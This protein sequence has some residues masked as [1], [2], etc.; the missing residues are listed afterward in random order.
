MLRVLYVNS[1]AEM[2]GGAERSLLE[3][4]ERDGANPAVILWSM[5]N[6]TPESPE[7]NAF[8][9]AFVAD[10]NRTRLR[11][12]GHKA[13]CELLANPPGHNTKAGA[14]WRSDRFFTSSRRASRPTSSLP[15]WLIAC[16]SRWRGAC[17]RWR[18]G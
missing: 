14:I 17:T 5:S 15:S 16:T 10:Y 13:P 6:E 4:I 2:L 11:C 7:R 1:S 9:H 18:R 12:L 3:L 8:I